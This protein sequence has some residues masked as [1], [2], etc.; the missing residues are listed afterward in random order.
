[1][2]ETRKYKIKGIISCKCDGRGVPNLKVEVW[3]KD[4]IKDDLLASK[5]KW[6]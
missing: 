5:K 3:D 2:N 1:M 4:L 6:Q